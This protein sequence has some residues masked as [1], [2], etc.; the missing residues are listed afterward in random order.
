MPQGHLLRLLL[1]GFGLSRDCV[2]AEIVV[3]VERQDG[4]TVG[5]LNAIL[6]DCPILFGVSDLPHEY[7]HVGE[8]VSPH[9]P[10]KSGAQ[11]ASLNNG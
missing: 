11:Q 2:D 9:N 4:T 10:R 5:M 1:S 8:K 6:H 3:E 7:G